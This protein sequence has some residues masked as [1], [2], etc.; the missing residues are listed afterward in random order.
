LNQDY[1]DYVVRDIAVTGLW[2]ESDKLYIAQYL[3]EEMRW[4]CREDG[5][6]LVLTFDPP[7]PVRNVVKLKP[8]HQPHPEV[9]VVFQGPTQIDRNRLLY[10]VGRV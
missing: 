2:Y 3:W 4:Q 7:D 9:V 1:S 10:N 5:T 8:W 6:T